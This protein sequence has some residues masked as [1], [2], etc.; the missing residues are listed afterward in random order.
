MNL[1]FARLDVSIHLTLALLPPFRPKPFLVGW[2]GDVGV[3]FDD[4]VIALD[5]FDLS[6]G[7]VEV[8]TT[9]KPSGKCERSPRLDA[10]VDRR[11]A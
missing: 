11:H 2:D 8:V 5:N 10:E 4:A 1:D 7:F 3:Q 6:A 9:T